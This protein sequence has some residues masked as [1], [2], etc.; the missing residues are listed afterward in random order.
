MKFRH[1]IKLCYHAEHILYLPTYFSIQSILTQRV[2]QIFLLSA[3]LIALDELVLWFFAV[4]CFTLPL[5]EFIFEMLAILPV[6]ELAPRFFPFE[7]LVVWVRLMWALELV[8]VLLALAEFTCSPCR[9][10][11]AAAW[12]SYFC[13]MTFMIRATSINLGYVN[14]LRM[15]CSSDLWIREASWK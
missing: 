6:E 12:A 2:G 15:A 7:L 9:E 4:I 13:V 14:F 10:A 11:W 3:L 8:P 1:S 5:V